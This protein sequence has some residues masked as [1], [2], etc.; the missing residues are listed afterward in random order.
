MNRRTPAKTASSRMRLRN[1]FDHDSGV[2]ILGD[3]VR[4]K[5]GT[6][7]RRAAGLEAGVGGH[8]ILD[9]ENYYSAKKEELDALVR[10]VGFNP[11]GNLPL[12]LQVPPPIVNRMWGVP[13]A[14]G[15][16]EAPVLE[17]ILNWLASGKLLAK[18]ESPRYQVD[19][20]CAKRMVTRHLKHN[21]EFRVAYHQMRALGANHLAEECIEIA[22]NQMID[23][24]RASVMIKTR[25]WMVSKLNP[26]M[27]GNNSESNV[28]VNVGFGDA[29]EQLEKRRR[30]NALPAPNLRVID[31][32]P[33]PLQR[34]E[35]TS[36]AIGQLMDD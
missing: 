7:S 1:K 14:D 11:A 22:D 26:A 27:Y 13:K 35:E 34:I 3:L 33:L 12:G 2:P 36:A 30:E 16:T 10:W 25:M 31:V 9:V 6:A 23:V 18:F 32:E 15:S 24:Q 21:A 17:E 29:L 19:S 4:A 5:R 20:A 8:V 28:N